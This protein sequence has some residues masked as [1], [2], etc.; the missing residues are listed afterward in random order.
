[1]LQVTEDRRIMGIDNQ[2]SS[3]EENKTLPPSLSSKKKLL[4]GRIL[5]QKKVNSIKMQSIRCGLGGVRPTTRNP[6]LTLCSVSH[7]VELAGRQLEIPPDRLLPSH[8]VVAL[9]DKVEMIGFGGWSVK[10]SGG[11][12]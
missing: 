8:V 11:P 2:Q 12:R 3:K 5:P 9:R 10:V 4:K 6:P 1:V 7:L